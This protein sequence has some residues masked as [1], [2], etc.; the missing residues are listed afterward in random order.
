M[1][2]G[3]MGVRFSGEMALI[4]GID[5]GRD[6]T[7]WALVRPTGELILSGIFPSSD[8]DSF[9]NVLG[10]PAVVW[11]EN[12]SRWVCEQ[13]SVPAEDENVGYVAVGDGTG[14]AEVMSRTKKTGLAMRSVNEKGTTLAA[15]ALYWE[16]HRPTWWQRFLPRSLWVPP[17]VLDDLAAWAIA[18]KSIPD[19]SPTDREHR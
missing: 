7:G 17:R 15:R 3:Q 14:S 5:P 8:L 19:V 10:M 11:K 4:V 9:L 18:L 16:L 13:L 1:A 2:A 12:L 6:K